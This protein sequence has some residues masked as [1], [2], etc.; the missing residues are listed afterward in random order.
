MRTSGQKFLEMLQ[1]NLGDVLEGEFE[2]VLAVGSD[3][4]A[5]RVTIEAT[6]DLKVSLL[7]FTYHFGQ[8]SWFPIV[9]HTTGNANEVPTPYQWRNLDRAFDDILARAKEQK[10][11]R[12]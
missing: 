2:M 9:L 12:L 3:D 10:K 6:D 7:Q 1:N 8:H 4:N 11:L 5:G